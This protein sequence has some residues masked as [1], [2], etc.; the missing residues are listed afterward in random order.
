MAAHGRA[1]ALGALY[2][3][4]RQ[5]VLM[6]ALRLLNESSSAEDLTHDVFIEAWRRA[7]QYQPDRGTVRS[8][9][10]VIARSRALD[11]L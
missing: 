7:R 1:L 8:W 2:R 6:L 10:L 11:R 4:H 5:L 9:L 3:R